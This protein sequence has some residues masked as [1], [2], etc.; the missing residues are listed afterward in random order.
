MAS[1][2]Q[3]TFWGAQLDGVGPGVGAAA[4]HTDARHVTVTLIGAITDFMKE[5][6]TLYGNVTTSI[7]L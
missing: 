1:T 6:A 3:Q 4:D 2:N 5:P 7:V